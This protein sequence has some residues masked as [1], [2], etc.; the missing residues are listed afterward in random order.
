MHSHLRFSEIINL[1]E[2]NPIN[3]NSKKY[4]IPLPR[5]MLY[6]DITLEREKNNHENFYKTYINLK[7]N[8]TILDFF[9]EGTQKVLFTTPNSEKLIKIRKIQKKE[10]DEEL[11]QKTLEKIDFF[12]CIPYRKIMDNYEEVDRLITLQVLHSQRR[13]NIFSNKSVFY[14][15]KKKIYQIMKFYK[16]KNQDQKKVFQM[17]KHKNYFKNCF[18]NCIQDN[19]LENFG[20]W[21]NKIVIVDYDTL[22][23]DY[24]LKHHKR[25]KKDWNVLNNFFKVNPC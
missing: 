24:L 4:P 20:V 11:I 13:I 8:G 6:K 3:N 14:C 12:D 16:K 5:K 22:R 25:I 9:A 23:H 2:D 10:N 15:K 17:F 19:S 21:K 18:L 7:H 1:F